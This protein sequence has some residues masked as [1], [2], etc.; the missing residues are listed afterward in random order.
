MK[1]LFLSTAILALLIASSSA[2]H[3]EARTQAAAQAGTPSATSHQAL[4]T[5]Y[6]YSCHTRAPGWAD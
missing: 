5:T 4:L 1:G 3:T 2:L 6:C